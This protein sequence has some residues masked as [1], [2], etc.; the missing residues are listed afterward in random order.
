[1]NQKE[2]LF[3]FEEK[4]PFLYEIEANGVP[5]Y[6]CFRDAMLSFLENGDSGSNS[7]SEGSKGKV[8][9]RRILKSILGFWKFRKKKTLIFTSS[10]YRRDYN[11]NLA[12]EWL[13]DRYEEAV[14]FEWPSR[15]DAY[16]QAIFSDEKRGHYCPIDFYLVLYK[17]YIRL[18]KKNYN[19]LKVQCRDRLKKAFVIAPSPD[20]E[21]EK[22]AIQYLI[23]E[24]PD[25]YATT[26]LSQKLFQKMFR[27][28]TKV[29]R[30]VD[31]WG[32]ARENIAPV[33]P[34]HPEVIELQHGIIT[35]YH[36]GYVYPSIAKKKC[37]KF[38]ERKVLV[39]GENTRN[40]LVNE[41]VFL[42]DKVEVIGN[43]RIEMYKKVFDSK[44][45]EKKIFLFASGAIGKHYYDKMI[46]YLS[47]I[48]SCMDKDPYWKD[49]RIAI[50]LH[51]RE[52]NDNIA[53]YKKVLPRALYYDNTS[54]LYELFGRSYVLLTLASTALYEAAK[55]D[56]PTVTLDYYFDD[57]T[58]IYGFDTW[59]ISN[60][61][62]VENM[63]EKLKN[64]EEYHTYLRYLQEETIKFM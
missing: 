62:D 12:A 11:R 28:Y 43:P 64:K 7:F 32:S 22:K 59:K 38:F 25:S 33:I 50:K 16:D 52:N 1:M 39:Y 63:L 26:V 8:Y 34:T 56:V 53:K 42:S 55:F 9:P 21:G 4:Y 41:S 6:T 61:A 17:L 48:Q 49:Y 29:E 19:I 14:I 24:M 13:M 57:I 51:P 10:V 36:P 3:Q 60:K 15:Q 2:L 44:E 23:D 37:K 46:E 30:V 18:Q 27:R 35:S 47:D 40:T 31:F 45:N 58:K 5:V 54:Q 20:T